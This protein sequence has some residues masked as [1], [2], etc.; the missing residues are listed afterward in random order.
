MKEPVKHHFTRSFVVFFACMHHAC[1][2]AFAS[3]CVQRDKK[4]LE[5]DVESHASADGSSHDCSTVLQFTET[6]ATMVG[7]ESWVQHTALESQPEM[8]AVLNSQS[9]LWPWPTRGQ[10]RLN[11]LIVTLHSAVPQ[12]S[13]K[14]AG[15]NNNVKLST[16]YRA[17]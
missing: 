10:P 9:K 7:S 6:L 2:H 15:N 4:N 1:M 16:S 11:N 5:S 13:W 12:Q 14:L 8:A 3:K 17:P